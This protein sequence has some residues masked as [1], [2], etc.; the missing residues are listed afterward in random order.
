M[1][2]R[3]PV[4]GM[5]Y[6]PSGTGKTTDLGYSFP[7]A[8]WIAAPGATAPI[9]SVCG[10]TG[11]PPVDVASLEQA[12]SILEAI[13]KDPKVKDRVD[14]MIIDDLTLYVDRTIRSLGA[15][16]VGAKDPRQLWGTVR[17]LLLVLRDTARRAGIHVFMNSHEAPPKMMNGARVRGGPALPGAGAELVP[18]A[19][20]LVLRAV[21]NSNISIGWK[22][23]YRCSVEDQDYVSKDRHNVTPDHAPMNVG[24]IL[25]AQGFNIRRLP[26]MAWQEEIVEKI[27]GAIL[28]DIGNVE[29]VKRALTLAFDRTYEIASKQVDPK[30]AEKWAIW[31]Q[32][33]A[34]DRAILRN[35]QTKHRRRLFG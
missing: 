13:Q 30:T 23:E 17:I 16:G 35:A 28:T 34:Y 2:P 9:S 18:A 15:A 6:G 4:L 1:T 20:D 33:D 32:R 27:A 12:I 7:R 26:E 10:Y 14:A 21:P 29:F 24:E 19:C 11:L 3:D 22:A 5:I 25:R 31:T 8:L